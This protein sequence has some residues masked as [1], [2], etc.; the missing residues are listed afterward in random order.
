MLNFN[1]LSQH[2]IQRYLIEKHDATYDIPPELLSKTYREAAVLIPVLRI[3]NS[4]HVLFIRRSEYEGDKHSGQVAFAGGKREISDTSLQ[5]TSLREAEEEIGIKQDDV[6]ILGRLNKHHTISNFKVTPFIATFN[7]PCP[8]VLDEVEVARTFTVP[9]SW[10]AD[11]KNYRIEQRH[12]NNRQKSWPVIYYNKYDNETIW[13]A[14][15]RMTLS[16]IEALKKL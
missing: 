7:W 9:L 10:L 4:W 8:L 1:H 13:G 11:D 3:E 16:L 12:Y 15:A 6:S 2:D 14:T 5:M